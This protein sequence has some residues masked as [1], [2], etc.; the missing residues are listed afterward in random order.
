MGKII[1]MEVSNMNEGQQKFLNFILDRV[2]EGNEGAA[3]QLLSDVFRKQDSEEFTQ[4]D[5]QNFIPK[6]L[7]LLKP[8]CIDEVDMIMQG[9]DYNAI[10]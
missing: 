6:M 5:M 3:A 2:K 1:L 9:Y 8:E 4:E 7:D 10:Y